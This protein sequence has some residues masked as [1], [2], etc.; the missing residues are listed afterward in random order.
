M[1]LVFAGL[2]GVVL[3]ELFRWIFMR[4]LHTRILTISHKASRV[5][6]SRTLSDEQKQLA[7]G[8]YAGMMMVTTLKLTGCFILVIAVG[9]LLL[10]PYQLLG[11]DVGA[12]L[13]SG[14][15]LVIMT[16][17][18]LLYIWVR[19]QLTASS[20]QE[21]YGPGSRFLHKIALGNGIIPEVSWDLEKAL[22]GKRNESITQDRHVFIAGLAR[23]GTTVLMRRL[24]ASGAFQSLTYQDMPFVLMPNLWRKMRGRNAR[25]GEKK[26]RAHGD[27]LLVDFDSPE[28]LEEVFWRFHE[29]DSYLKEDRLVPMQGS[30]ETIE[31]FREYIRAILKEHPNERYLS[32]N[33]NNILRLG[34]LN[35]AFPNSIILIPYREPLQQAYSLWQQHRRFL[36][37]DPF[38]A[39]YMV[40][41]AHHEFGQGHR[42]FVFCESQILEGAPENLDYWLSLWRNVYGWLIQNVPG[43]ARFISYRQLCED[44]ES[45]WGVL[46][47]DLDLPPALK[48]ADHLTYREREVNIP[49]NP[50]LLTEARVIYQQLVERG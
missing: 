9:A 10:L 26:E 7:V 40:W 1:D 11:H 49:Y 32:K 28:A 23:A 31:E 43:N 18:S 13:A 14:K 17:V 46:E 8:A 39:K 33:N 25:S 24:F 45:V 29:G 4:G 6:R 27:G 42:P 19:S 38:T 36:D 44:T 3:G 34:S 12:F 41:L 15:V 37:S 2:L 20:T 16:L 30:E 35:E 50:S 22:L 47:R 48:N 5:V 21:D